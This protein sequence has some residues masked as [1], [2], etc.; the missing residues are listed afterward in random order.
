MGGKRRAQ[1]GDLKEGRS[2][3]LDG[4][5]CEVTQYQTSS[6]GKHGSTKVRISA[7]GIFDGKKRSISKPKDSNIEV[8]ILDKKT[9]Q[10]I[11][12]SGD[13]LQIMDMETYETFDAAMENVNEEIRD[14]LEEEMEVNYIEALGR[15]RIE[16]IDS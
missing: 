12:M 10:I 8:P 1:M 11:S 4:E 3:I 16:S 13:N 15:R 9:G 6:P 5:P 2:V 14:E 7:V